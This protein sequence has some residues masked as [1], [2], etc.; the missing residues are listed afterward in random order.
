M[1]NIDDVV[2]TKKEIQMMR[3]GMYSAMQMTI[4]VLECT[5]EEGSPIHNNKQR[6]S[7][8]TFEYGKI[9]QVS[10]ISGILSGFTTMANN[11]LK[12]LDKLIELGTDEAITEAWREGAKFYESME[13][14]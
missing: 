1:P 2:M 7:Q 5:I 11:Q 14:E 8:E 9:R 6:V 13:G 12:Q 3:T 4:N 10:M